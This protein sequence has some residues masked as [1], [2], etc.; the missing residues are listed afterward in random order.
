MGANSLDLLCL[1]PCLFRHCD[2][3]VLIAM[4]DAITDVPGITVGHWTDS[5]AATGCTVVLTE[6][7]A[8]GGVD[9]RG[10]APGT[11]ETDLLRPT[12]LVQQV[13]GI[14]LTGG[15]AFGLDA[16][17]GVVRFLEEREVGFRVRRW[18]VPIVAG[19]V[20]FDLGVGNGQVR[21]SASSGYEACLDAA[22]GPVNQGSVGAG[23]GASVGK[24]C[25]GGAAVKGGLGT[26]SAVMGDGT[27][28]AAIMAVNAFGEVVSRDGVVVAGP[29]DR[30]GEGF[31]DTLAE[32]RK[33]VTQ[34][35][36]GE[37]TTIGVVATN[38]PLNKEEIN[39]V[40]QMAQDGVAVAVR[41]AHTMSDGDVVFAL[42][43]GREQDGSRRRRRRRSSVTAI[44]ALAATLV[45]DS[46]VR[47]VQEAESTGKIPAVKDLEWHDR[48]AA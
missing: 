14:I 3:H 36:T 39:K 40:A 44:G 38:A 11:R 22:G 20:L 45:A 19:A 47:S 24:A 33:G 10:A 9:V 34:K 8:V 23:T 43:T 7:G 41:P 21:P 18:R 16:A 37:N 6:N 46:I 1:W 12:N 4:H 30:H 35:S 42:A 15:S 26:A 48:Y 17:S 29:R 28:V 5:R 25:G 13:Q 27:V 2:R 31:V 32:L